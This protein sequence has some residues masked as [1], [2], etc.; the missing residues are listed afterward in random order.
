[1][2]RRLVVPS[3]RHVRRW[4]VTM[5]SVLAAVGAGAAVQPGTAHANQTGPPF[6]VSVGSGGSYPYPDD[7]PAESFIASDGTYYFQQSESLYGA[8]DPRQW[9]FYTGTNFGDAT[10]DKSL[11]DAV[12]PANPKDRNNNT[13]WRCNNSPTGKKS[14]F[15]PASS[16]YAEKN[17]CD[18]IGVWVDPDTG[19]WYGL[20]HNEFTPEPFGTDGLHYDAIDYAVSTNQ[21]RTWTIKGHVL[22]SPY[23]TKRGDTKAFP[24]QT[25]Y[26]GDGDPRL[27]VD[28]ASGYFYVYY[29]SRT[30]DKSGGWVTFYEHVARAPISAKMAPSSW[31]KYYDG[32]WSQPGTGGKESNLV[33]VTASNPRGYTAPSAEYKPATPGTIQQQLADGTTPPTSPLFVTDITWDAYLGVYIGEPQSVDQ[34]G[35]APQQFYWTASL[36]TQKWHL[37][38]D[39]GS[40]HD[41]SWYRWFLDSASKTSGAIVGKTFRSYCAWA[42]ADSENGSYA[43]I[44]ITSSSP[45]KSPVSPRRTYRIADGQGRVLSQLPGS[46]GTV[47]WPGSARSALSGWRFM[48]NGDGSYSI[49]NAQ[50]GEFLGVDSHTTAGRAWGAAPTATPEGPGGLTVGQQWWLVRD[51]SPI[52]G[53]PLDTFR[54]VNR[55]SDLVLGLPSAFGARSE[56]TPVRTWPG[57]GESTAQQV[58]TIESVRIW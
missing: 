26:Y 16:G 56:T 48:S 38:G 29:G 23:A 21:G 8:G 53:R 55:Y 6:T 33:P 11:S 39:T 34:S 14:T 1:M 2:S 47:S 7:T 43:N 13:T 19:D 12:N 42:C 46:S 57:N 35:N 28:T 3:H 18:L 15:A 32:S 44:T 31:R 52:T 4:L 5:V 54:L 45:V 9:S 50:S 41:A 25:Y 24:E 36:A 49:V 22:T 10:L 51:T 58:M 17:Y 37:L 40:L 27:Y 20:V 30:V